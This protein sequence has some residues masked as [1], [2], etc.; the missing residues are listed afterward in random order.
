MLAFTLPAIE[1]LILP[2]GECILDIRHAVL[3]AR[4]LIRQLF[5]HLLKGFVDGVSLGYL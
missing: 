1:A 2:L 5:A 4:Q 3:H